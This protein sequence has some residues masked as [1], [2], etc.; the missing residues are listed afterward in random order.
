M[1]RWRWLVWSIYVLAW[2]VALLYPIPPPG[3]HENME[4]LLAARQVGA[5]FV[6]VTAYAIMAMLTG[7]LNVPWRFRGLLVFFLMA[8][9]TAT[10]IGQQVIT[11]LHWAERTGKLS[12]VALDHFGVLLGM[13]A[14]WRWWA[15]EK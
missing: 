10:E 5:K 3:A 6:H 9:A 13:L 14:G 11:D 12:D 8:H 4:A 15:N 7:W 1:T 2:T